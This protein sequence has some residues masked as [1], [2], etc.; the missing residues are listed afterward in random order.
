MATISNHRPD[1][2]KYRPY[3]ANEI[4][5]VNLNALE[6]LAPLPPLSPGLTTVE[7]SCLDALEFVR[8]PRK[9]STY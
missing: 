4:H 9:I 7:I 2:N 8:R 5:L 3:K 6:S 1:N